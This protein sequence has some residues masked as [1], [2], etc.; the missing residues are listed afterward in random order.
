M[1][2]RQTCKPL[3]RTR[4]GGGQQTALR[5]TKHTSPLI[6]TTI[7]IGPFD[8]SVIRIF[9][10]PDSQSMT[11]EAVEYGLEPI[12]VRFSFIC[13]ISCCFVYLI[14]FFYT[15]RIVPNPHPVLMRLQ[16]WQINLLRLYLPSCQCTGAVLFPSTIP[17]AS[18]PSLLTMG[19]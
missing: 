17:A 7:I 14:Q 3:C 1:L 16:I 9:A 4:H 12:Q 11:R 19:S 8:S 13:N 15:V 18:A 10:F 2:V 6:S 5:H